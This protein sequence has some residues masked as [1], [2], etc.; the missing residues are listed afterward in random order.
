MQEA[1]LARACTRLSL[2]YLDILGQ[3]VPVYTQYTHSFTR[4]KCCPSIQEWN[5]QRFPIDSRTLFTS[6]FHNKLVRCLALQKGAEEELFARSP[7]D[8][9]WSAKNAVDSAKKN[10]L[11]AACNLTASGDQCHGVISDHV[12]NCTR[13]LILHE[14][15]LCVGSSRFGH[16]VEI[17]K[18]PVT[19]DCSP[20]LRPDFFILSETTKM[21]WTF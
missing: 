21:Q 4:Y 12:C 11:P 3:T 17:R 19:L 6:L 10:R 7:D 8:T 15:Q 2:S 16:R 9:P 14:C 13:W 18:I 1:W 20:C 5:A